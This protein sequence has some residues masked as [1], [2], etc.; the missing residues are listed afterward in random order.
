MSGCMPGMTWARD[1]PT[2][3]LRTMN[4]PCERLT[5][6][7]TPTMRARPTPSNP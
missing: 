5:T 7:M 6:R 3:A 4:S 1:T 2:N